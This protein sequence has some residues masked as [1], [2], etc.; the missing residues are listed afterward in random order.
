[1]GSVITLVCGLL[2]ALLNGCTNWGSAGSLHTRSLGDNPVILPAKYLAAFFGPDPQG[3][4]SFMLADVPVQQ[5][6]DRNV[7]QAQILHVDLLWEPMPGRT[8][9]D[10]SATNASLRLVIIA[11]GEVGLYGGAGFAMPSGSL[12]GKSV[13]LT[14]RD[15]S[16]QL[17][18]ATPGFR[19][20]LS[21]AEMTGTFTARRDEKKTQQ[22]NQAA[23][24]MVTDALGRTRI[25][26]AR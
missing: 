26:H 17:L 8:P 11:D 21:P 12:D 3:S 14:L 9:I 15:A 24:Q 10:P 13:T 22:L 5:V 6:L 19:D 1:M 20:L 7:T 18:D 16:L 4:T 23:S 25:V 2:I